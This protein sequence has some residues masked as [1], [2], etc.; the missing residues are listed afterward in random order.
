MK[1]RNKFNVILN[2]FSNI[3]EM[4]LL[5][6]KEIKILHEGNKNIRFITR[7]IKK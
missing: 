6:M 5:Y 2:K 1:K 3:K 4:F 7:L